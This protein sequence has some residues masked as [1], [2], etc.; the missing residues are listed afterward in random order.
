MQ[1][2]RLFLK[3]HKKLDIIKKM[4]CLVFF[5]LARRVSNQLNFNSIKTALKTLNFFKK[6]SFA[7]LNPKNQKG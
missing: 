5:K 6:L 2:L 1:T 7:F 4:K 3:N